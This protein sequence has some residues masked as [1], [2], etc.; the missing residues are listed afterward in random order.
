[1]FFFSTFK[2]TTLVSEVIE[3]L[4]EFY[5][6]NNNNNNGFF[7]LKKKTKVNTTLNMHNCVVV[8]IT[9]IC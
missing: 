3:Q 6:H 4:I 5:V 2:L 1:M 8:E 9:Y 7:I